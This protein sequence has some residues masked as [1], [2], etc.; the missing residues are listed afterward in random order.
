MQSTR[1][2]LN[3]S[4]RAFIFDTFLPKVVEDYKDIYIFSDTNSDYRNLDNT[5][6]GSN[7]FKIDK[8]LDKHNLIQHNKEFANSTI[9]GRSRVIDHVISR[10][11]NCSVE[12]GGHLGKVTYHPALLTTIKYGKDDSSDL[13]DVD[14]CA[15]PIQ[16]SIQDIIETKITRDWTKLNDTNHLSFLVHKFMIEENSQPYMAFWLHNFMIKYEAQANSFSARCR[17]CGWPI[18]KPTQNLIRDREYF[19][20]HFYKEHYKMYTE[21]SIKDLLSLLTKLNFKL[22]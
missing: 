22:E 15:N 11:N 2:K 9:L 10:R 6:R 19:R 20:K 18:Y 14:Y 16:D 13:C 12:Y 4:I 8:F 1:R 7:E 21:E 3:E 5:L 17:L